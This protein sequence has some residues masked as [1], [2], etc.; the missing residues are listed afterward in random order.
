MDRENGLLGKRN[1]VCNTEG[2]FVVL[3]QTQ[4][5][6]ANKNPPIAMK[7]QTAGSDPYV[8]LITTT[9]M[10]FHK[11]KYT[12][13]YIFT[14]VYEYLYFSLLQIICPHFPH[15]GRGGRGNSG[16]IMVAD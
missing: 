3:G 14:Y 13:L 5:P 9:T 12:Y 2:Q 11:Y 4:K 7:S 8:P 6:Q 10:K 1:T 15:V 16:M